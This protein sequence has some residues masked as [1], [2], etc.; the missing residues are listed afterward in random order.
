[1]TGAV[2]LVLDTSTAFA[3]IHLYQI[4]IPSCNLWLSTVL[5]CIIYVL[6]FNIQTS[7]SVQSMK[8]LHLF[9]FTFTR[10]L[11]VDVLAHMMECKR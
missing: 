9:S 5:V 7:G 1:M 6:L 8:Y 10:L 11:F 4:C 3:E 2:C